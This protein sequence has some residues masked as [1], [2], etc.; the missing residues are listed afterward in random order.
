MKELFQWVPWF[1]ELARAVGEGREAG[2]AERAK[3]VDWAG[4][5]CAVL[6][7]GEDKADPLTFFYHLASIAGGTAKKRETVYSSVAEV[8]GIKSELDYSS[9][10]QFF[11]PIPPGFAVMFNNT[12]ADPGLLWEM[13][14]QA[15]VLDDTS[16]GTV[17]A[18][19]F[20]KVLQIKGVAVAK[21]TQVLFL[22]NPRAFLPFDAAAVLPLGI[23][24]LKT[25][26]A[27][28][29][30]DEYVDEMGKVRAAFPSCQP[31]EI[32]VIGYLWT[33]GKF[34]RKGNRWY[35]IGTGDDGWRDFRDNHWVHLGGQ[36]D[37]HPPA[38]GEILPAFKQ[39]DGFDEPEPGDVVL[40]HTGTQE[41]RGIGIVYRNDY[42]ERSHQNRRIHVLWVNKER[43][44]LA[45]KMPAVRFSRVGRTSYEAFAKSAAYSATLDLL[46]P[47]EPGTGGSRPEKK[48]I[49]ALYGEFYRPLVARLHQKGVQPEERGWRG[50]WR[51]CQTGYPGAVY[52]M[53]LG[54]A[55]AKVFLSFRGAGNEQR[56]RALLRHREEID[57]KVKGTVLWLDESHGDWGTTV[58]LE[59]DGAFDLTGPEEDLE[60]TRQWM[61]DILLALRGAV[62]PHLDQ[63]MR[64][65]GGGF[66]PPSATSLIQSLRDD[67]LLF[68]Q[69]LVAN[70]ILA[71]QT[72]RF[73]I[74]TGISGT[75]KTRIAKAVAEHF[76]PILQSTVARIPDDAVEIQ[77]MPYQF[78]Y[79]RLMVPREVGTNL[80]LLG[81]EAPLADRQI[82]ILYPHGETTLAYYHER[83]GATA[84]LFRGVFK[85]WFRSNVKP[86]DRLWLRV[87]EGDAPEA[88]GL[89]IGIGDTDLVEAPL[90]N[91]VVIPVRP[92]WVDNRGL[93]GYLNPLTNEYS[94]TP[95][96][97]LLLRAREE[98]NRAKAADEKPH[99]FFVILDE[100]NLARVEHYFS[101]FLSAL[102]SGEDIPLHEDEAI[103]SG[104]S[105]SGPRVPRKLKV[106][107]NVL[108]TG[109]VNVDETTYMFSPKVLDRAFTIEFDQVDL[110]GFS[111][112]ISSEDT[113]GLNLGSDQG[114]LD[115]L[116]SGWS[117]DDWKPS[118]ADWVEFSK[119]TPGHHE[120]LLRL[121]DILEE[122]H[123]HFGYRVANEIAR[124]VNLAR[125]QAKETD[126]AVN[127]AFDL[128]LLQKVLPKFHGTQQELESLLEEIFQFAV[129][130][131]GHAPKKN[132]TVELDDWKVVKGRLV[133]KFKAQAPSQT[134]SGDAGTEGDEAD[135]DNAE[136]ADADTKSPAYPRTGAK[137]LRM[138]NRLRDRGFTSFIE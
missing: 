41:G 56:F 100:M 57:G 19:T 38:E 17:S 78:K 137:V 24:T 113:S 54:D 36:A 48:N 16:D 12:G 70:Y 98:E 10:G 6:D 130:G 43:A 102:E 1:R 127:A 11:F 119:E 80:S 30:W 26:P 49:N 3:K 86:G 61:A 93:L 74:L 2:L 73:A 63:V 39:D 60:A 82:Q 89:D 35:Q 128:A 115:L 23:G 68:S 53:D 94:T 106:P 64:V 116:P 22:I 5:R 21:L 51:S 138:L 121:H 62:Q 90:H 101:D 109:T 52:G 15:R 81:P 34:P 46:Q 45:A 69:E 77:V 132:Q 8:F 99:P 134:P 40:V 111:K 112:D 117:D 83:Q 91:Y 72:K 96:L 65:A 13:F 31:Y 88:N 20:A 28:M 71:L 107:G 33:S 126:A 104:E 79:S 50:R 92:D 37:M 85:K 122:Q 95:F 75:G 55:R 76:Q 118:R 125:E 25:N 42:G 14:D 114:S 133:T 29:S 84:L 67:G 87:Q 120:A 9:D 18:D 105:E 47:P 129:Y 123:R 44:P 59:R 124:F 27:K 32:N 66:K 131:S 58:L 110:K 103:D 135:S 4:G 136:A 97:N 108:F 7:Q